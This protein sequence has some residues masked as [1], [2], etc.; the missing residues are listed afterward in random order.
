MKRSDGMGSHLPSIAG[1]VS[2]PER[3]PEQRI[4]QILLE[5]PH[6]PRWTKASDHTSYSKVIDSAIRDR[7]TI[8]SNSIRAIHADLA[9]SNHPLLPHK[10][11]TTPHYVLPPPHHEGDVEKQHWYQYQASWRVLREQQKGSPGRATP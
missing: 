9:R 5:F 4:S 10:Q 6:D 11:T 1:E 3:M 2:I 7:D 8:F